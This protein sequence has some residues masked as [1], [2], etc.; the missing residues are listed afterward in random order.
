MYFASLIL[1]L[2]AATAAS[3]YY[4][5]TFLHLD[6]ATEASDYLTYVLVPTVSGKALAVC[7]FV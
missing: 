4:Y 5:P 2:T 3:A 6:G 1:A 7:S